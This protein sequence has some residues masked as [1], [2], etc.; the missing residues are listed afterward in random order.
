MN[1]KLTLRDTSEILLTD[2]RAESSYGIPVA[3][4]NGVAYGKSD[5]IPL[6]SP[7]ELEWLQ[8]SA[9]VTVAAACIFNKIDGD[10]LKFAQKFWN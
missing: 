10:E 6:P 1:L 9:A 8:E 5:V 2:E 4:F 7:P 3:I